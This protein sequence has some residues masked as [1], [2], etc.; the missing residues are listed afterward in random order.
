M[1]SFYRPPNGNANIR[2]SELEKS[3]HYICNKTRNNPNHTVMLGGDFNLGDIQWD[4]ESVDP[5]SSHKSSSDKL[6][7]LPR[8]HQLKQM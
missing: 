4:S 3:L 2:L 1:G 7:Q 5:Q 6:V 8:D